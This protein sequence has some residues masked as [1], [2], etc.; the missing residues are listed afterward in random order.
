MMTNIKQYVPIFVS[1]TYTDLIPYRK[2]VWAILEKLQQAVSGMEIFG[3]RPEEPLKTCLEEVSKCEVFVGIVGMRYGSV[4]EDT[5]KSFV[6]LEYEE[7]LKKPLDMLIYLVDEES[8]LLPPK[9]VDVGDSAMKLREFKTLL[10]KKHTVDYFISPEDLASK[11][12]RDLLRLFH[13]KGRVVEEERLKP[14]IEPQKMVELLRKFDLM[15]GRFA[16]SEVELIIKFSGVPKRVSQGLCKAIGLQFGSSLQREI[17][18]VRPIGI[19]DSFGFVNTIYAE[20]EACDFLYEAPEGKE[21]MIVAK[22]SF[23]QERSIHIQPESFLRAPY[24]R[25]TGIFLGEPAKVKDLE[26]GEEFENYITYSPVKALVL[27]KR[28]T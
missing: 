23:G 2:A 21:H 27:V 9:F 19:S 20:Y 8:A 5:G 11:V 17:T 26:T 14:S 6:Q 24:W 25:S 1:S 7:A 28:I 18:V 12:E 15:P 16:G 22:L 4:H 10:Q 3:A 13:D